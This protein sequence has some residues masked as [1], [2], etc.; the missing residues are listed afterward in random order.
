MRVLSRSR[1]LQALRNAD[2]QTADKT[3]DIGGGPRPAV[4]VKE[5]T[6]NRQ[7]GTSAV[8]KIKKKQKKPIILNAR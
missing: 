5:L 1:L 4:F 2:K 8:V 6:C 7:P 3:F